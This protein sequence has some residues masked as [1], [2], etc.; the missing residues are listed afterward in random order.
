MRVGGV[1]KGSN[2][3]MK[4]SGSRSHGPTSEGEP[5]KKHQS[6]AEDLGVSAQSG[7]EGCGILSGNYNLEEREKVGNER[8]DGMLEKHTASNQSR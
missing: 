6:T 2:E 8:N 5:G 4:A 3:G 1:S 7:K